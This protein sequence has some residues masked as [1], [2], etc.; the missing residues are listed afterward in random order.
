[1][2]GILTRNPDLNGVFCAND[3]MALGAIAAIESAGLSDQVHVT[4]YDNL[5][6]AQQAILEGALD[7]TIEQHPDRMGAMGVEYALKAINGETFPAKI[8]V[9]T[10]LITAETLKKSAE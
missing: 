3:N 5:E 10:D 2:S 6:A 9:P 7:A 8:E 4:G 1:M